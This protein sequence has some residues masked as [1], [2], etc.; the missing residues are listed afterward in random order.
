MAVTDAEPI[1]R[2]DR[3][4]DPGLGVTHRGFHVL[5]FGKAGGDGR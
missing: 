2:C 3:R 1:G 5:A 4:A